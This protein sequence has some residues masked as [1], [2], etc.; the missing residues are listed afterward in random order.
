MVE[1]LAVLLHG[2]ANAGLHPAFAVL[3]RP[4]RGIVLLFALNNLKKLAKTL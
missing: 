4:F 1:V 2:Q 3:V